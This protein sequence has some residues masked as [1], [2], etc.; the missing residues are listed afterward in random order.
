MM[1]VY[2]KLKINYGML[3]F[4]QLEYVNAEIVQILH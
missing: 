4:M 1:T 2:Q 3:L